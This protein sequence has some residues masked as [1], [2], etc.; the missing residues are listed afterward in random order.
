MS[1]EDLRVRGDF[2]I[3]AAELEESASRAGGPGG[4]HVNKTSTRVSLRYDE[5]LRPTPVVTP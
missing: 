5:G 3:P 1:R 2:V 4:Q